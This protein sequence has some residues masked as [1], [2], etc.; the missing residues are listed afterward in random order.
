VPMN[1]GVPAGLTVRFSASAVSLKTGV[2]RFLPRLR[3]SAAK[4]AGLFA[5]QQSEARPES[6]IETAA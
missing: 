2:E 3:Q 1:G 4:I 6:A 5:E